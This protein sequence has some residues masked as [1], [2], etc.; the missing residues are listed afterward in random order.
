[1]KLGFN[2][3]LIDLIMHYVSSVSYSMIIN[4]ETFGHITPT[5]GI[6]QGDPISPYLFLLYAKGL[7]ALIHEA[8]QN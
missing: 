1:M 2:N 4:G 5:R 6:R 7:S 8:A 3:K